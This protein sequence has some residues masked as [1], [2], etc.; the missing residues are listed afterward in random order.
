MLRDF[1]LPPARKGTPLWGPLY[2]AATGGRPYNIRE[3]PAT[4][5]MAV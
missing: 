3:R 5:K 1:A 4:Q 2:R